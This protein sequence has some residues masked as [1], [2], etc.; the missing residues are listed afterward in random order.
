MIEQLL[1]QAKHQWLNIGSV[2]FLLI[3]IPVRG[4]IRAR[5]LNKIKKKF[6]DDEYIVYEPT[7]PSIIEYFAPF[8]FGGATLE[9]ILN[10]NI[11]FIHIII[12]ALFTL[13]GL[14]V[15]F[16]SIYIKY[17]VTNKKVYFISTM[18]LDIFNKLLKIIGIQF[19]EVNVIDIKNI[20]IKKFSLGTMIL[21][22]I[23]TKEEQ[24]IEL[25][26][27]ENINETKTKINSL[28]LDINN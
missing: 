19:F 7:I 16:L 8:L 9:L 22:I 4:F 25:P 17:I 5:A 24:P 18:N 11:P 1:E 21:T 20:E 15:I 13:F 2:V 28:K 23:K 27:L 3:L 10:H 26:L 6:D 12:S 14:F